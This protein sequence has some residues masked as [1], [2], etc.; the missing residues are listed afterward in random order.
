MKK[1]TTV[2]KNEEFDRSEDF[3]PE[4]MYDEEPEYRYVSLEDKLRDVGMSIRDF[5]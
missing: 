1:M 3:S 5:I 4:E 2:T